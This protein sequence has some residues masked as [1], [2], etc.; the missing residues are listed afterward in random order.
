[1]LSRLYACR[2]L[3]KSDHVT[4][5]I[6]DLEWL[7]SESIQVLMREPTLLELTAPIQVVGDVHGQFTDLLKFLSQG[8]PADQTKY[9]F[10]GDYVDRG[11]HSIETITTL[12]CLKQLHPQNIFLLRGNHE[13]RDISRLYGFAEECRARFTISLWNRF[14]EL[15]NYLPLAAVIS[16]RI[17]C[18]HGGISRDLRR[19]ADIASIRRPLE[20]PE[21]G[22]IADLLWADPSPDKLGYNESERGTSFT[23]GRDVSETLLRENDLDLI[24][25]AHQVVESGFQF[26]FYPLQSVVTVFSAPDYCEE[27]GNSGAILKIDKDLVC[28]F[29]FVRPPPKPEPEIV[30]APTPAGPR[31]ALSGL[32]RMDKRPVK[33]FA[34]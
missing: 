34:D 17:F 16:H 29:S 19:L 9:L 21:T 13:T 32:A 14:N 4:L 1:M 33:T 10:L 27:Y 5:D 23:Y 30:R 28:S 11:P 3:R 20:M 2:T 7:C 15:F 18:V 22:F 6:H 24:C 8:G 26:P 12:L 25:R 31:R